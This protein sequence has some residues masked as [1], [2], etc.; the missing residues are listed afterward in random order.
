M[1]S[2]LSTPRPEPARTVAGRSRNKIKKHD[3]ETKSRNTI[4]KHD[5]K[6]KSRF[7]ISAD[8]ASNDRLVEDEVGCPLGCLPAQ[9]LRD[10]AQTRGVLLLE[11]AGGVL[12]PR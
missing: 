1:P 5:Q 4:K 3:Q 6:A 8:G 7:L 9:P 10:R 2:R 12:A 11:L